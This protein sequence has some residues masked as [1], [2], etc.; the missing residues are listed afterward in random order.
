MN[1]ASKAWFLAKNDVRFAFKEF[2]TILWVVIMPPVFFFFL[3]TV[4]GQS[5]IGS[6]GAPD[7]LAIERQES[8]GFFADHLAA[9]L[10]EQNF[11]VA[12]ASSGQ[13]PARTLHLPENF[14]ENVLNGIESTV[15]FEGAADGPA[16]AYEEIRVRIAAYLALADLVAIAVNKPDGAS[17]TQADFTAIRAEPKKITLDVKPAG[18]RQTIPSGFEQ[19]IPGTLVMFTLLVLLTSGATLLVIE[20]EKGVLR[21]LASAPLTRGTVIAG[22]WGGKYALG[23][24]QIAVAVLVG[25]FVFGMNWGGSFPMVFA[26]LMAWGAF[27]A[28]AGLL[29]GSL[30][31]TQAQAIGLGVLTSNVLAALGGCWWPIEITPAWMQFVAKLTPTGWTMDALHKLISFDAGAMS[32]LPHLAALLMGALVLGWLAAK[33]FRYE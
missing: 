29:L 33:R 12:D 18:K 5:T 21:R 19:A 20:R 13:L 11:A 10:E 9:R 4:T 25:S 16:Q 7:P 6:G 23:L 27:C 30:A 15:T 28:S 24:V 3:G 1:T 8:A 32:A 31:R 26:V 17:P 2:A 14:T 22:K